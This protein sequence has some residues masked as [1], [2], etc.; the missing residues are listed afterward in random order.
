MTD[1]YDP[2]RHSGEIEPLTEQLLLD[3]GW[4]VQ[5]AS[6]RNRDSEPEL[7]RGQD[8]DLLDPD[9]FA[10]RNGTSVWVEV[11][12]FTESYYTSSRSQEE[13]G[14]RVDKTDRY[15]KLATVSSI[16]VWLF[17]FEVDAGVLYAGNI[18]SIELLDS[19]NPDAV[20]QRYGEPMTWIPKHSLQPVD[21]S[22]DQLPSA[23]SHDITVDT[24]TDVNSLLTASAES[25]SERKVKIESEAKP[26][27][28][29][30]L[31][32]TVE[33]GTDHGIAEDTSVPIIEYVEESRQSDITT[34]DWS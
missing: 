6:A 33:A 28:E 10:C 17:M 1:P 29:V 11:K 15:Q 25:K 3:A 23:F 31:D 7:I 13:Y 12:E 24:G 30:D 14:L 26:E 16:P 2:S 19:I 4:Y 32:A 34:R 20:R 8:R 18:G 9:I 5:N 27:A 22:Q 21:V